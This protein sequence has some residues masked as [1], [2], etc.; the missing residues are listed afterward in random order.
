ML[1]F[2]FDSFFQTSKTIEE[3]VVLRLN[4]NVDGM[5]IPV[6]LGLL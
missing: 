5:I 4:A 2:E 3:F 1:A 6:E